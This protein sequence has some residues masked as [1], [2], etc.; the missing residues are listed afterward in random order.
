MGVAMLSELNKYELKPIIAKNAQDIYRLIGDKAVD[1]PKL[2]ALKQ[3]IRKGTGYTLLYDKDVVGVLLMSDFIAHISIDYFYVHPEHR[4]KPHIIIMMGNA[5]AKIGD[6]PVY[7]KSKDIS[8]FR[9]MAKKVEGMEDVYQLDCK[10]S[11][12]ME[13]IFKNKVK[14]V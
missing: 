6:K 9:S 7:F 10:L 2:S 13:E 8:S 3:A 4:R 12:R 14:G 1:M 5:L 11:P